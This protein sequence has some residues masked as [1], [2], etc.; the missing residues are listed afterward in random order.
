[1]NQQFAALNAAGK[2][3]RE[4]HKHP[5]SCQRQHHGARLY[6]GVLTAPCRFRSRRQMKRPLAVWPAAFQAQ[7]HS[8]LQNALRLV[9]G[10]RNTWLV[11]VQRSTPHRRML[12][13]LDLA[14]FET[15][16]AH[17]PSRVRLELLCGPN[18]PGSASPR[19]AP[20]LT[21]CAPCFTPFSTS[22]APFFVPSPRSE[23]RLLAPMR[24]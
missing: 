18:G 7:N 1:M 14:L 11:L 22:G 8:I 13:V 9:E 4:H 17:G 3:V 23:P 19:F 2:L 16:H 15:D 10:I 24:S 12:A 6:L 21:P 5:A 20:F